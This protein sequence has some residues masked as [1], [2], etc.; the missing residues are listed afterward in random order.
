MPQVPG[1]IRKQRAAA[2][3]ESGA[4]Q[5]QKFLKQH[6]NKTYEAVVEKGLI[7]RTQHFAQVRLDR[8]LPAGTLVTVETGGIDGDCLTG[9]VSG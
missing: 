8:E 7:G 1:N 3:R 4:R 5:M 2:L 6:V 9:T